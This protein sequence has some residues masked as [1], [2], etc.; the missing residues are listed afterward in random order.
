MEIAQA[1][2]KQSRLCRL[3]LLIFGMIG[4]MLKPYGSIDKMRLYLSRE[5]PSAYT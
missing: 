2:I 4:A 1:C 3:S 5:A